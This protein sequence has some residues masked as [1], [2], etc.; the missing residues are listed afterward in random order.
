MLTLFWGAE[1]LPGKPQPFVPP[2]EAAKLRLTQAS[3]SAKAAAGTRTAKC[4]GL[5]LPSAVVAHTGTKVTLNVK[6][7]EDGPTLQLAVLREDRCE[8]I[9]LV[10][11]A[12]VQ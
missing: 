4:I 9:N 5:M 1:V 8:N 7:G 12:D 11:A 6:V 3:L 10:R 2:P